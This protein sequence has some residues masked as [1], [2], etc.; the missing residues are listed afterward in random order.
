MNMHPTWRR[1]AAKLLAVFGVLVLL[2]ACTLS[3]KEKL[4]T[5]NEATTPLP[6]SFTFFAY[7]EKPEGFV[8]T[9]EA[10]QTFTLNGKGYTNPDGA[11][12]AYFVPLEGNTY[13]LALSA[14]DGNLYGVANFFDAGV[15][16]INMVFGTGLEQAIADAAVPAPIASTLTVSDGGIE[17]TSREA[18][19][20]VVGL[21]AEGKL[22]TAPLIA[23]VGETPESPTPA[24]ITRDGE[25]WK[26]VN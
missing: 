25:S 23:Y 12:A 13:L 20:F 26:V 10:G 1:L 8:R 21:I 7:T 17:V 6:Q 2:A 4:V 15:L 22:P 3:S 24:T 16:Q 5:D 14:A 19:D 18:L 11:M 9:D